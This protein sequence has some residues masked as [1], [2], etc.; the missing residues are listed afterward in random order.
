MAIR[1]MDILSDDSSEDEVFQP[2]INAPNNNVI[3]RNLA[4]DPGILN[5]DSDTD[6]DDTEDKRV[7]EK[8]SEPIRFIGVIGH[9]P[10]G[11]SAIG[12]SFAIAPLARRAPPPPPS[13]DT[14]KGSYFKILEGIKFAEQY[15]IIVELPKQRNSIFDCDVGKFGSFRLNYQI[16]LAK[17]D[18]KLALDMK[19]IE[20]SEINGVIELFTNKT[21]LSTI[22]AALT[23]QVGFNAI[24]VKVSTCLL[25]INCKQSY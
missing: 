20:K 22:K 13:G 15:E 3:K 12:S 18:Q 1:N 10:E 6:E 23:T 8:E 24:I 4:E 5:I 17:P 19:G 16:V 9:K 25:N 11:S 14:D 2:K 21:Q 7:N